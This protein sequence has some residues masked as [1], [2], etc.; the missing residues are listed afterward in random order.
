MINICYCGNKGVYSQI[1]LSA[2]S[3]AKHH[4]GAITVYLITMDLRERDERFLPVTEEQADVLEKAL[5]RKNS[6]SRA[7]L[8][9][10]SELYR[11]YYV[12][13]K[14]G[15]NSFTPYAYVRLFADVLPELASA[16]KLIYLDADV[17]CL[18]DIAEL[19]ET[20]ISAYE[21]AAVKDAVGHIFVNPRYCNSGVLLLNMANI[22]KTDLL[23]RARKRVKTRKMFM[24]D[25]SAL[26][27]LVKKKL[28]LPRKFNEQRAIRSDTVLKHFCQQF[29]WYGPFFKLY[30][31]KQTDRGN[32]HNVLHIHEF[33]DIYG[34][35]DALYEEFGFEK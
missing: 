8:I 16:E 10:V 11:G 35:Y 29:K 27:F 22:R 2:L 5:Q 24:P 25:Q 9:D 7:C 3:L 15:K 31:Y 1:L 4:D 12:K 34:Q 19:W 28:I 32:V 30:N 20:D 23:G 26:N 21:F 6:E 18:S 17:M 13:E 33:D 14:N